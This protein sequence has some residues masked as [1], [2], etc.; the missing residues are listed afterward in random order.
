MGA[1]QSNRNIKRPEDVFAKCHGI[2]TKMS[3]Q[4]SR[5]SRAP[6]LWKVYGCGVDEL[7]LFCR[8]RFVVDELCWGP[9]APLK[10]VNQLVK[11]FSFDQ[12]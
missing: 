5:C 11:C 10:V 9:V 4:K 6:V 2:S 12:L 1:A 7:G 3:T 8:G